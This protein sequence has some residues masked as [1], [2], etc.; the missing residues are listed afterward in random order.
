MRRFSQRN[1]AQQNDMLH[2]GVPVNRV[3]KENGPD[4]WVSTNLKD[5]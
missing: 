1:V 3:V 5:I 4:S 2:R